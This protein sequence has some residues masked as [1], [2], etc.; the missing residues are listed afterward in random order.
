MALVHEK[1]YRSGS[2]ARIDFGEYVRHLAS[3]LMRSYGA[4]D[5]KLTV[6][7][8]YVELGVDAAVPCGLIV[9]ELVSNAVKHGFRGREGGTIDVSISVQDDGRHVLSVSDDGAGFPPHIDFRTSDSLG[10]QLVS[11]LT[12]QLGGTVSLT[13]GAW[14]TFTIRF[15]PPRS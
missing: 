13:T 11:T 5:I 4:E 15:T 1:L 12:A 14:T 7:A 2:L 9:H 10:L 8:A 6:R 3:D